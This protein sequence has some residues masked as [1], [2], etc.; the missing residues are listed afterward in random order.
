MNAQSFNAVIVG[1]S[2]AG[3][4]AAILLARRG[5]QVALVERNPDP[6]AYKQLCT[7]FIQPSATATI[8]RLGLDR[9][10]EA[11][12]GVRN[13]IDLWTRWGWIRG[14]LSDAAGAPLHGYNLRRQTLDPLVRDMAANTPGVTLFAGW[15]A[16]SLRRD[17][18]R[19]SGVHLQGPDS[20]GAD[21]DAPLVVAAD[22]RNSRLAEL[23][24]LRP[25]VS[26][27]CRGGVF[28]HY[29]NARLHSGERSQMWFAEPD[30]AYT[31]PNDDGVILLTWMPSRER[32]PELQQDPAGALER[33]ISG[34]PDGPDLSRAER[35]TPVIQV[36]NYPNLFRPPVM[37]GMALIGDAAASM[38]P[39]FGVGCGW[40]FQSAEWLVDAVADA[41]AARRS[42]APGLK[43]YAR[44]YRRHLAGHQFL[45]SDYSKRSAFNPIERLMYSAAAR[46]PHMARH[47][48]MFGARLIGPGKFLSPVAMLRAAWVNLR[49]S[50]GAGPARAAAGA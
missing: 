16:Q 14:D 17:G 30:V 13:H 7:H 35:I 21:L 36:K 27:N 26:E 8:R 46:D 24:G 9:A 20:A 41:L 12:G 28:A 25:K 50:L 39:L 1:A 31:F 47:F 19:I 15:S 44:E 29:R 49:H 5:L 40:A 18:A 3:C 4:T 43:H 38:D 45:V 32:M 37:H 6:G 34:L 11:S 22:G 10:I 48:L 42:P 2:L 23:A 33:F